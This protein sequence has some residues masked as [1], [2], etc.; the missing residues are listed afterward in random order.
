MSLPSLPLSCVDVGS[1]RTGW[2][3]WGISRVDYGFLR[4]G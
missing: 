4:A 2:V 3:F 1:L